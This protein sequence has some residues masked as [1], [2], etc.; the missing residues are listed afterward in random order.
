M[1]IGDFLSAFRQGKELANASTWT[2]R[3]AATTALTGFV[4]SAI[5]I[6]GAFGYKLDIDPQLVQ[7]AASGVV[8]LV[9]LVSAV[10]HIVTNKSA[11][12]PAKSEA[13]PGSEG[14]ANGVGADPQAVREFL[15][16]R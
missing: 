3:A 7:D 12:L 14:Y 4:A 1:L 13:S 15:D 11:G 2:N 16:R 9:C 8:A 5:A 10:M 6:A